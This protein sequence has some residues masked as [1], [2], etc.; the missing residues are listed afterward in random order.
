MRVI[1]QQAADKFGITLEKLQRISQRKSAPA[2][3]IDEHGQYD[4]DIL[5]KFLKKIAIEIA[6]AKKYAAKKRVEA[7][8]KPR[9]TNSSKPKRAKRVKSVKAAKAAKKQVRKTKRVIR[10]K[11]QESFQDFIRRFWLEEEHWMSFLEAG[12]STLDWALRF[13]NAAL[14]FGFKT[15]YPKADLD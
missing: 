13:T 8:V 3:L 9:N 2:G 6:A 12:E 5:E 15:A 7:G 14:E 1:A 11:T 10:R 4:T